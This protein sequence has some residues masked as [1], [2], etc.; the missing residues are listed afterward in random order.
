MKKISIL[1]LAVLS[2]NVFAANLKDTVPEA[3]T[4][5]EQFSAKTGV[6][7]VRGFHKIGTVNGLYSTLVNVESKEFTNVTSGQKEYGITIEAFKEDGRYDK[8]HTSY[9]DYDEIDS[10]IS[11]IDYISKIKP[12]VTKF[13]DF[14]ADYTTKGDLKIS[15]FSSGDRVMAAVSSGKIGGVA[16]YYNLE[17]LSKIKDLIVKAKA[18]IREVK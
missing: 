1:A 3:K 15:T 6:V 5:L 9:I 11:G 18:K 2:C 12:D 10:L 13:Q 8:K 16:A 7:L 17:D 14:Q 4:K